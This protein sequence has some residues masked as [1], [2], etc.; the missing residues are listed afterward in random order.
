MVGVEDD[1]V[2]IGFAHQFHRGKVEE[3][4]NR[5][6]VEAALEELTGQKVRVRCVAVEGDSDAEPTPAQPAQPVDD[7]TEDDELIRAAVEKLGAQ[8]TTQNQ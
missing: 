3:D 2:K 7:A 8:V 5:R 4:D 6:K 1:M